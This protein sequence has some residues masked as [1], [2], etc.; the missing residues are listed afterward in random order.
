MSCSRSNINEVIVSV[1]II[2]YCLSLFVHHFHQVVEV[3]GVALG[4]EPLSEV[5]LQCG[6]QV[7]HHV[8]VE[9]ALP[10]LGLQV[11]IILVSRVQLHH[12]LL[13]GQ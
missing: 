7:L 6:V 5:A 10:D 8:A 12:V 2:H 1:G 3:L 4:D 9:A 13:W 11:T